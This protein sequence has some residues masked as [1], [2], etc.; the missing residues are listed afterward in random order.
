[1]SERKRRCLAA[2]HTAENNPTD[3]SDAREM[4]KKYMTLFDV[5]TMRAAGAGD[6]DQPRALVSGEATPSYLLYGEK[7]ARRVRA[8]APHA[9]LVIVVRDPTD[10]LYSHYN[11]TVD[12]EG[13]AVVH[14]KRGH[15]QICEPS[16][17]ATAS[18]SMSELPYR[19][20]SMESLAE[21]DLGALEA[22]GVGARSRGDAAR[23]DSLQRRYFDRV[24]D[25]GHGAHSWVG[26]GLYAAQLKLWLRHFPREQIL[27]VCSDQMRTP[28]GCQSVVDRVF[29]HLR[30]P[31]HRLS[32]TTAKNTAE[33]RGRKGW[34]KPFDPD[35]K[36]RLREFYRPHNAELFQ[37]LGEDFGWNDKA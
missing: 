36:T 17:D 31:P 12:P 6:A 5:A 4:R 30:L 2:L 28:A 8:V 1:M 19:P 32:D 13:S 22:A 34:R 11:M 23:L 26:R 20:R 29:A 9:R 33:Q 16:G 10:R 21:E 37:M 7:V 14:R 25:D 3:D 35:L 18:E 24:P 15:F 27:V